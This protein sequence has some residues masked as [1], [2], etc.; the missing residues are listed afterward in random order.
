MKSGLDR[1]LIARTNEI[2]AFEM[3]GSG[4]W[5]ILSTIVIKSASD[6]ADNHKSKKWQK[7]A[8][9]TAAAGLKAFLEE[10]EI[11]DQPNTS[12]EPILEATT[13]YATVIGPYS[14]AL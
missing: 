11:S 12:V 14:G 2:V 10:W 3:E 13:G 6:Y 7:Y 4:V 8:A 1:D 5:D 9:V